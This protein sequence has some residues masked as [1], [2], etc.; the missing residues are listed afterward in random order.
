MTR[1]QPRFGELFVL[2][3]RGTS[4]ADW[5]RRFETEFGLGGVILFDV[6][7]EK[8]GILRNIEDPTQ[9]R[10]LCAEIHQ[11]PSSPL[12]FIDQE[13]GSVCRLKS[14]RGFAP[15]PSAA[16]F[17]RLPEP[18]RFALVQESYAEMAEIGINF[19]L[20]PVVDLNTN[21][22]NPA[23]GALGRSYSD[24]PEE[25]RRNLAILGKAAREAGLGLC[26]KHFPGLGGATSDTHDELTDITGLVADGQLRLFTDCWAALPGRAILLSHG[27]LRNW[28]RE[29]PVSVSEAAVGSLRASAESALLITDDLQMQGMQLRYGT[30][31]AALHAVRAG[32][33]LLCIANNERAREAEGFEAVREIARRATSDPTL[34]ENASRATGR[35]RA[36]KE[37]LLRLD[38]PLKPVMRS[39]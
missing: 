10:T 23:I 9:L 13:G 1:G 28:D 33:D 27:I 39:D 19:N 8:K 3:F 17:N 15:L 22:R 21:P 2:G 5:V 11:L 18:T 31:E 6:D 16:E 4:L 29:N 38:R 7:V 34:Y 35:V 14:E 32:V 30:V 25:V 12:I 26:L 20:A 37:E 24:D 36:R